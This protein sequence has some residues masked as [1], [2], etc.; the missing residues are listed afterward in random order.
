VSLDAREQRALNSIAERLAASAPELASRLSVFNRL[1]SG[2]QIPEDLQSR[3]QARHG[4]HRGGGAGLADA[5]EGS[6]GPLMR[7]TPGKAWPALPVAAALAVTVAIMI[8]LALVLS[9]TS[10]TSR[11]VHQASHCAQ[12]WAIPCPGR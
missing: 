12:G 2:E 7:P 3:V 6:R 8:T 10:H 11:G 1:T 9:A 4:R 5:T